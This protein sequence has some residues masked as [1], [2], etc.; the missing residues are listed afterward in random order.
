MNKQRTNIGAPTEILRAILHKS[1]LGPL[2]R[3]T[4]DIFAEKWEGC[5]FAVDNT[6]HSYGK[7]V[8]SERGCSILKIN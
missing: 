4:I 1:V 2:L 3:K 8:Y 7:N 6:L 5:N